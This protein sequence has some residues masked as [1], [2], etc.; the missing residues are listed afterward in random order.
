M[1]YVKPSHVK[2]AQLSTTADHMSDDD[3]VTV[4]PSRAQVKSALEIIRTALRSR[5][6][7]RADYQ[8]F[9]RVEVL[10]TA[11][12]RE[13]VQKTIPQHFYPLHS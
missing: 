11:P 6:T 8:A 12:D 7:Q 4:P 10:L 3:E 1:K 5:E 9:T 2:V 13:T